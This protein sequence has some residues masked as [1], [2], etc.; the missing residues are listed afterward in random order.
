MKPDIT[1]GAF[2]GFND[3]EDKAPDS[4]NDIS[5]V[6]SWPG[7]MDAAT[8]IDTGETGERKRQHEHTDADGSF[9]TVG[10]GGANASTPKTKAL[11]KKKKKERR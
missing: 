3:E 5:S 1:E 7:S 10:P 8:G 9:I 2:N 6:A 11:K 4:D